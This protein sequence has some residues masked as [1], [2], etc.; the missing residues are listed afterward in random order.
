M[1][2]DILTNELNEL[3]IQE[4]DFV[5]ESSEEQHIEAI[6]RS[7]KG[8]WKESPTMGV[9]IVSEVNSTGRIENL[10]REIMLQLKVDDWQNVNLDLSDIENIL[11]EANKMENV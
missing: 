2:K 3:I 4:G 8:H 10:E 1:V 9:G 6:L 11:I 5:I 7:E